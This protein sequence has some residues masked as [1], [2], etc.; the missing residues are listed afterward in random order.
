MNKQLQTKRKNVISFENY[1]KKLK[2]KEKEKEKEELA[3]LITD[4]KTK[5]NTNKNKLAPLTMDEQLALDMEEYMK[6]K[7]IGR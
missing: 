1:K 4:Q 5:T 3:T 7:K 6:K 2:E